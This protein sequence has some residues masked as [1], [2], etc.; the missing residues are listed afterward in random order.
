MTDR[1][2]HHDNDEIHVRVDFP[3]RVLETPDM[4]IVLSDGCRL[5]ARVWMP[6]DATDH[7]VPAIL[8]YIPYRKRDGTPPRDEMMHPYFAG[9]GYAS[10]RVDIRGCGDSQGLILDE[11][12]EQEQADAEEV[13]AWL[14]AQPW[15]SGA[16]GMMGKSWGGLNCVQTAFRQPPAL[17]AVVGVCSTTDRFSEDLHYK[18]GCLLGENFGWVLLSFILC[19]SSFI[20]TAA[21]TPSFDSFFHTE[22]RTSTLPKRTSEQLRCIYRVQ[23]CCPIPAARPIRSCGLIGGRIG[24]PGWKLNLGSRRTGLRIK[25]AMDFGNTARCV[26][27]TGA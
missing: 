22:L 9:H 14:A 5:S 7:P 17:K 3:R 18:G 13:I 12:T 27:I 24:L 19:F 16:V 25:R 2:Q 10:V 11:Y 6:D 26:K 4:G 23:C 21:Y 20:C 8:E 15:C 1:H